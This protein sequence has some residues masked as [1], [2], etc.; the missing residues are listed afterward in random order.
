[1]LD[2]APRL[3]AS[4]FLTAVANAELGNGLIHNAAE[5]HRRAREVRQLEKRV[6]ELE[7]QQRGPAV[8]VEELRKMIAQVEAGAN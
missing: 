7:C 6:E 5:F 3:S 4:D 1:M 2:D 8:P